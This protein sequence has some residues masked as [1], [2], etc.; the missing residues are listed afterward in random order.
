MRSG[1]RSVTPADIYF[2]FCLS[3]GRCGGLV[4]MA[5]YGDYG[6]QLKVNDVQSNPQSVRN[7]V[8]AIA[9]PEPNGMTGS[10]GAAGISLP[11]SKT[12]AAELW[13][14]G[15]PESVFKRTEL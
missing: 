11:L 15:H 14:T 1:I 7:A 6:Q 4:L 2:Y 3:R 5:V 10:V 12:L 9:S 13:K 8:K